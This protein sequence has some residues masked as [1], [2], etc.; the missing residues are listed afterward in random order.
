MNNL[1]YST[2]RKASFVMVILVLLVT[3]CLPAALQPEPVIQTVESTVEVTVEVTREVPVEVTR[4]VEVPVTIT[5]TFTPEI[6]ETP[7]PEGTTTPAIALVRL[8]YGVQCL[9]GP[10]LEFMN[11]YTMTAGTQ[12]EAFGRSIDQLWVNVRTFD[13]KKQCWL[14]LDQVT[15]DTGS[16]GA[17]PVLDPNLAPYSTKQNGP[18]QAV[19]TNRVGDEVTIFWLPVP[20][21]E[22]D[23]RGY[24][25]EAWVC[26]D[27]Q[28]AFF[29]RSYVPDY[30]KNQEIAMQAILFIDEAGC[31]ETSRAIIYAA[32]SDGYS[33]PYLMS[34]PG[35]PTPTP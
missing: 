17:L 35:F 16:V 30:D 14:R 7:T 31:S 24:L 11:K 13:L 6:L 33:Q 20:M 26:R 4:V 5:P 19:S 27:G 18:V 2:I 9:Y 21:P 12:L 32:A 15:V 3:A 10:S 34:W 23:Y 28:Q 29:A 25:I 8:P 1:P 22:A